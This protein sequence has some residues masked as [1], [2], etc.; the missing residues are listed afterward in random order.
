MSSAN[1]LQQQQMPFD[2]HE[3]KSQSVATETSLKF[4]ITWETSTLLQSLT[5]FSDGLGFNIGLLKLEDGS[6][7]II[8]FGVWGNVSVDEDPSQFKASPTTFLFS[9]RIA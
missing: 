2:L 9:D 5:N 4:A 8:E 3:S 6:G 7:M 1:P